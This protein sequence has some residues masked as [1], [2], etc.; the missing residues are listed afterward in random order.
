MSSWVIRRYSCPE[1]HL[2]VVCVCTCM[3]A[4]MCARYVHMWVCARTHRVCA[5]VYVCVRVRVCVCPLTCTHKPL[6]LQPPEQG[7]ARVGGPLLENGAAEPYL[8][9]RGGS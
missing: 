2:K 6:S 3:C 5:C 8:D 1:L 4:R 9:G 7:L